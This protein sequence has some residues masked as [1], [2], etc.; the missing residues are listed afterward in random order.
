MLNHMMFSNSLS[1]FLQMRQSLEVRL[2]AALN[3]I[4]CAELNKLE[5]G[6]VARKSFAEQELVMEKVVQESKRLRQQA[7][8]NA[9]VVNLPI[10]TFLR[11]LSIL[12]FLVK[13]YLYLVSYS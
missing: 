12:P 10:N 1:N 9:K 5:K 13:C 4:Q 6:E 3:E 7:E 2:A 8:D 11:I